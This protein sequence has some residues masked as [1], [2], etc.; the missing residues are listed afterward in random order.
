MSLYGTN[1]DNVPQT[2]PEEAEVKLSE[3]LAMADGV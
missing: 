1:Q 2:L 3:C